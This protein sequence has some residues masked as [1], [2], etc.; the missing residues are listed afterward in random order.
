MLSQIKEATN[1]SCFPYG[2]V[3]TLIFTEFGVYCS[4]EDARKLL[5]IDRYNEHSH[6]LMGYQKVDDR[7]VHK[8]FK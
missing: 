3:F 8:A 7:W 1:K 2:M 5:H 6:H 4:G